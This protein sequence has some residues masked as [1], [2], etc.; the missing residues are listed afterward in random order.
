MFREV[1]PGRYLKT[2]PAQSVVLVCSRYGNVY[3]VAPF[4][5]HMPVSIEPPVVAISI[6]DSRDTHAN[7]IENGEYVMA[8]P[9]TDLV[10]QIDI[11]AKPLP[12]DESEFDLAG[13]T[14]LQSKV[15]KTPGVVECQVNMECRLM[16]IKNAGDHD[17]FVG[18]VVFVNIK[19][20]DPGTVDRTQL[21]PIY[22]TAASGAQYSAKGD[23]LPR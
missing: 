14:P 7:I 16:W 2:Y 20:L 6:R 21:D 13:L 8:F 15:I 1:E 3:N 19:D 18:E 12:R 4:A 23:V 11:A 22:H 10:K 5:W 17:I 9:S